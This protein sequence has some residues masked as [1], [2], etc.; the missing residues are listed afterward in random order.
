VKLRLAREILD[1]VR[2]FRAK[3]LG[4]TYNTINRLSAQGDMLRPS[5]GLHEVSEL[6]ETWARRVLIRAT[7]EY[8]YRSK[9]ESSLRS[10]YRNKPKRLDIQKRYRQRIAV[11]REWLR[12]DRRGPCPCSEGDLVA[13][14]VA[15][16]RYKRSA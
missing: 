5:P 15:M 2:L 10:Y 12:S 14:A 1:G 3:D 13:A 9:L 11:A 6:S 16:N 7:P 8:R 4:C